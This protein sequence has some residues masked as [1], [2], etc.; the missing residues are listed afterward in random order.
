LLSHAR[1]SRTKVTNIAQQALAPHFHGK[2]LE[3]LKTNL[4][5]VLIDE[6]A[7][8]SVAK[9]L[10]VCVSFCDETI[11]IQVDLLALIEC[12]N[13]SASGIFNELVRVRN[14]VKEVGVTH[15]N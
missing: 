8:Q 7:D 1:L 11:K 10:P 3:T 13:G 12:S 4:F 9:Q 6:T 15:Q 5:S 14:D 2:L